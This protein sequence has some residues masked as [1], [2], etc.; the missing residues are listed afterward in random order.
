MNYLLEFLKKVCR[1]FKKQF[2]NCAKVDYFFQS[3]NAF[4][5]RN[6]FFNLQVFSFL[7]V[8]FHF[9]SC[10]N[11]TPTASQQEGGHVRSRKFDVVSPK[12]ALINQ[13]TQLPL[14]A[15]PLSTSKLAK[16]GFRSFSYTRVHVAA[17]VQPPLPAIILPLNLSHSRH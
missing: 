1:K 9:I 7:T 17:P 14:S 12:E 4:Q 10:G 2:C 3:K 6:K 8:F 15:S 13:K 16:D 11:L 5:S